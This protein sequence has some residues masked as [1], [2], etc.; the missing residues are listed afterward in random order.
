[1]K[2]ITVI[3]ASV[4]MLFASTQAN[5]QLLQSLLGGDKSSA[6]GTIGNLVSSLAGSVYS[7]PISLNGTYVYNGIAVDVSKSE[8]GVLSNLAGTAVTAGI[9][10]KIDEKLAQ[11]GIKPGAFTFVFVPNAD[12][13]GGEFTCKVLNIPLTGTFTVGQAEKTVTLQFSK[14]LKF[15]SMTGTLNSTLN[16]AEMVFP[17]NKMLT[18][19]KKVASVAGK[20][21]STISTITSLADGYDNLKLGFKLA[22]Q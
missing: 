18:F 9:E 16:G 15:L 17:A 5:A 4:A 3:L 12:N 2:K 7:A 10:S 13:S 21:S 14:T 6:A 20:Y 22:K 11:F 19:L 1:M 8:G